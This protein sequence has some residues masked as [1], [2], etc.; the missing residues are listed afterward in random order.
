MKT[1]YESIL[2]KTDRK[3]GDIKNLKSTFGFNFEVLNLRVMHNIANNINA[4]NEKNLKKLTKDKGIISDVFVEKMDDVKDITVY[5]GVPEII[6]MFLTYIDNLDVKTLLKQEE[7]FHM[8]SEFLEKQMIQDGVCE[9]LW[10]STFM[11]NGKSAVLCLWRG[12]GKLME[13]TIKK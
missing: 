8:Y 10:W 3:V 5:N 2:D 13:L 4:F 11:N 9:T 12:A 1:L 6:E 7:D